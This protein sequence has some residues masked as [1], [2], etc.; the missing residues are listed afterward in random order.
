MPGIL[1]MTD[2]GVVFNDSEKR[3]FDAIIFATGYR[4]S[5]RS[6]LPSDDIAPDVE[7]SADNAG[8]YFVGFHVAITGQLHEIGK[9]AIRV[10]N[11]IA[12]RSNARAAQ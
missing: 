3:L 12:R 4:P 2:D 1:T 8:I 7:R 5:Y 9:Q 10:A 6:F 11:D